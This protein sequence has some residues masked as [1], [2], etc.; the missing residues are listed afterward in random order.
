MGWLIQARE[1]MDYT[2]DRKL[3][4][5][6]LAQP[7]RPGELTLPNL[8]NQLGKLD[9]GDA[10][11]WL[12]TG[13]PWLPLLAEALG[14]DVDELRGRIHRQVHPPDATEGGEERLVQLGW[15]RALDLAVEP[16][17]PGLPW[18]LSPLLG[19]DVRRVWWT[20]GPGAGKT[21]LG[22]WLA[23]N[24]RW[25]FVSAPTW[26]EA[27]SR[28]PRSGRVYVELQ[29]PSEEPCRPEDAPEGLDLWVAAPFRPGLPTAPTDDD[30][31]DRQPAAPTWTE[32]HSPPLREWIDALLA[33]V[34]PR[35]K[36]GGRYD[37]EEVVALLRTLPLEEL[38]E[39]PGDLLE[40]LALTDELGARALQDEDSFEAGKL[41]RLW[42]RLALS[43]AEV[44]PLASL[45][46]RHGDGLLVDLVRERL[47][48]GLPT[49]LSEAG[50]AA[51]VPNEI[52][53]ELDRE[54]LAALLDQATPDSLARARALVKPGA[55][56]VIAAL[57]AVRA[58]IRDPLGG[59]H[60]RPAWLANLAQGAAVEALCEEGPEGL[61]A[62]LLY[63]PTSA[64]GLS[65][66]LERTAAG[67]LESVRACV[68]DVN[69]A[70]PERLAALEGAFRVLGH[71][72]LL[73]DSLPIEL[74]AQAWAAQMEHIAER[75]LNFPPLPIIQVAQAERAALTGQGAWLRAA[76]A[77]SSRLQEQGEVPAAG[78]LNPWTGIPTNQNE[79]EAYKQSLD[80][81]LSDTYA[82]RRDEPQG[83]EIAWAC[84]RLGV[85]LYDRLGPQTDVHLLLHA[86]APTLLVR[87]ARDGA[88]EIPGGPLWEAMSLP[89]GLRP[90]EQACEAEGVPITVVL[91]WLWTV[92]SSPAGTGPQ[93]WPPFTWSSRDLKDPK[94][95]AQ[96]ERLWRCLPDQAVTDAVIQHIGYRPVVWPWLPVCFWSAWVRAR[97]ERPHA[98]HTGEQLWD[99]VPLPLLMETLRTAP[100]PAHM[101]PAFGAGWR[102]APAALLAMVDDLATEPERP[103]MG[104]TNLV[105]EL[106]HTG[107]AHSSEALVELAE[108]WWRAP[109]AHPGVGSGLKRWLLR[110]VE[111]RVPGWRRAFSLLI[112][113]RPASPGDEERLPTPRSRA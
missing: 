99:H 56:E 24:L 71:R 89:R 6:L 21:L 3:A 29:Q 74:L 35:V 62:L 108:R 92:W 65:A 19:A 40:L 61:G 72:L 63:P 55:R 31:E 13:E 8:A 87:L 27:L 113:D 32:I 103:L 38:F 88:Q 36:P 25:I 97:L 37:A 4:E 18:P 1:E 45:L 95:R 102:R 96:I 5:H 20:A 9:K 16:L 48:H 67:D 11:W 75:Y 79:R 84:A 83:H 81:A 93:G 12:A 41:I 46:K 51:L 57:K 60:I 105:L 22:R 70:S 109:Q 33:W 39:S 59:W 69:R 23:L 106:I 66:L 90:I 110:A 98:W 34:E 14:F 80:R 111:Q 94:L 77:I 10:A 30:G 91:D 52:A 82:D 58:L 85:E 112:E 44:T 54:Q 28:L 17:P 42:L 100:L 73:G 47:R 50:W 7:G 43:R 49:S 76:L 64:Q 107:L 26:R 78:P 2:S 101:L 86:V 15:L 68:R 104:G 53:P